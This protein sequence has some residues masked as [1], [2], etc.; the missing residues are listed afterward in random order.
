MCVEKSLGYLAVNGVGCLGW[1]VGS[2][3]VEAEFCKLVQ[4]LIC[5]EV[6]VRLPDEVTN[7]GRVAV[8]RAARMRY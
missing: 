7:M 5:L 1:V 2:G 8:Y 6:L 3:D 4:D